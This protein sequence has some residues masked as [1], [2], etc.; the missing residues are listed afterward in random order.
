[1]RVFVH[2]NMQ[3]EAEKQMKVTNEG[4][5][6]KR[7]GQAYYKQ[8]PSIQRMKKGMETQAVDNMGQHWL[9]QRG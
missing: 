3:T 1:M 6:A 9:C 7:Y 5:N 2:K 4:T 8:D